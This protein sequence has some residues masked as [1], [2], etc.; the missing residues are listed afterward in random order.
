[1]PQ[2]ERGEESIGTLG[3]THGLTETT[4][5]RWRKPFGGLT[6]ADAPR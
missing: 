5:Y 3:R 6:V 2:A 1:L 4:L